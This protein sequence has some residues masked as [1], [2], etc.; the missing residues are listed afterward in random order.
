MATT[1]PATPGEQPGDRTKAISSKRLLSCAALVAAG[2]ILAG[3]VTAEAK[4]KTPP[5]VHNAQWFQHQKCLQD[6]TLCP[7]ASS[8]AG[9]C[10]KRPHYGPQR[11]VRVPC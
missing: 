8:G 7:S 2:V 5:Q 9:W 3:L 10:Y 11:L 6:H 4:I 1:V